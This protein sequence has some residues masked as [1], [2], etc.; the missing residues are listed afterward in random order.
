[1]R[2]ETGVDSIF[3]VLPSN[4][5]GRNLEKESATDVR[6]HTVVQIAAALSDT[7]WAAKFNQARGRPNKK[8]KKIMHLYI[9]L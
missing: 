9:Y 2:K 5:A 6:R 1:M 3:D 4:C 7:Y 8:K